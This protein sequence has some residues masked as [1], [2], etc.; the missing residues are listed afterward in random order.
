MSVPALPGRSIFERIRIMDQFQYQ[1]EPTPQMVKKREPFRVSLGVLIIC[2]LLTGVFVFMATFVP[3]SLSC[4]QEV[5]KAYGRFSKFEKLTEIAELYDE[6]Y[7]YEVDDDLLEEALASAYVYGNGDRFSLYYSAD[8]WAREMA[9]SAGNSVGLGVYISYDQTK[10]LHI[11]QIMDDSPAKKADLK[12]GDV[13]VAIDG[14]D[15]LTLG[16]DAAADKVRGEIG[17]SVTLTVDRNGERISVPVVRG[18][19]VAQTVYHELLEVEGEKMGYIHITEFMSVEVTYAQFKEAVDL[20]R[21][22]GAKGLIFDVRDNPGGDLNAICSILDYLLPQG[23]IVRMSYAGSSDV[24]TIYS[25]DSEIDMPMIVLTNENT[26]SA[27]ELF[28]S[29]LRDYDKAEI[30]GQTTFGKGCGQTG[31]M[32]SDG[33]MVFITSFLYSPP[34]SDNYDGIGIVPDHEVALSEEWQEK[35]LFLVPHNEDA[36]LLKAV[37]V[38][39]TQIP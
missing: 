33:S 37:E 8:A 1:S 39:L 29:A 12:V 34:Y 28:T 4:K 25:Y 6:A 7:L 14:E 20:L 24:E 31:E 9:D 17:S 27:A 16:F 22:G 36:Q 3:L 15:V 32:L 13:I 11:L 26:A 19:Y 30:V 18:Q 10:G 23:P 5:E 21:A 2:I 35:N 38:L